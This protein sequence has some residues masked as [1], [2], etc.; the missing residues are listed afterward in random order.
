[1]AAMLQTFAI[2]RVRPIKGLIS[3]LIATIDIQLDSAL[4][5]MVRTILEISRALTGS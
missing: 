2:R 1:M 5:P 3:L 4:P